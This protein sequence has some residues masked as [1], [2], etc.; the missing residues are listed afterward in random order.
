MKIETMARV[1]VGVIFWLTAASPFS[2]STQATPKPEEEAPLRSALWLT[3]E[4]DWIRE[5]VPMERLTGELRGLPFEEIIVQVVENGSAYYDSKVLPR[6]AGVSASFDPL[7]KLATE[8]NK[9]PS[10]RAVIAW[11]DPLR[12]GNVNSTIPSGLLA[13]SPERAKWLAQDSSG[14]TQT[15][16]G[17]RFLEPGLP[18][19]RALMVQVMREVAKYPIDGIYI[20][21]ICDPGPEWGYHPEIVKRW[22]KQSGKTGKPDPIDPE[23]AAFRVKI[24]T[25]TVT[26]LAKAAR[27]VKPGIVISVGGE[28]IG[29]APATPE[30]FKE[31]AVYRNLRQDWPA[32]LRSGLVNL[33]YVK[34]FH[35]EQ[36]EKEIFDGWVTFAMLAE[37]GTKGGAYIGVA[38]HMNDAMGALHQLQRVA[39]SEAYG[40]ALSSYQKPELD[41]GID[42]RM[43]FFDAIAKTALSNAY[44]SRKQENA[45]QLAKAEAAETSGVETALQLPPPPSI[46]EGQRARLIP[47]AKKDEDALAAARRL[48]GLEP[49][50]TSGTVAAVGGT[51]ATMQAAAEPAT[52]PAPAK[53]TRHDTLLELL[54]KQGPDNR[55]MQ[56]IKPT[57][58]TADYLKRKYG[59]LFE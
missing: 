38:G 26:E 13:A 30:A 3:A 51:T 55:D 18:E 48:A 22:A 25:E 16:N 17:D 52:A 37:K 12:V 40:L 11:V 10:H 33:V 23:W 45:E 57:G 7:K 56:A 34:N 54:R 35:G 24:M 8:L 20:D 36:T 9:E 50:T 42:V 19:V 15:K 4:G 27:A 41:V 59:N 2:Q 6:A 39:L 31:S 14:S 53:P 49:L 29:Q 1:F 58:K 46:E 47:I 21:P 44:V 28:A 5:N 43:L 32:W